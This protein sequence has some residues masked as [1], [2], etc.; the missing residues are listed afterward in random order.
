MKWWVLMDWADAHAVRL[1]DYRPGEEWSGPFKTY[2]DMKRYIVE[3]GMIEL[4]N[5][6]SQLREWRTKTKGEA[7][8]MAG[9]GG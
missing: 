3:A 7:L 2:S 6:A 8:T 1:V 4:E 5:I 9:R